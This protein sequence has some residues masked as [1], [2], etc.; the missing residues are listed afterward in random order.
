MVGSLI[1]SAGSTAPAVTA[2]GKTRRTATATPLPD[3]IGESVSLSPF[4]NRPA[5]KAAV[6]SRK[7]VPDERPTRC[8]CG[9]MFP[10][11]KHPETGERICAACLREVMS[12]G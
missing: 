1:R 12:R 11:D 2:P 8:A 6:K 9:G 5:S 3:S 10:L 7:D 4:S